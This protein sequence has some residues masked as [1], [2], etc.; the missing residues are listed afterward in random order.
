MK[1]KIVECR[2]LTI[3]ERVKSLFVREY[4]TVWELE[5]GKK[6]SIESS[7]RGGSWTELNLTPKIKSYLA[8][9]RMKNSIGYETELDKS[10]KISV[11]ESKTQ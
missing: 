8:D 3:R 2:K 5:D 11:L 4:L 9:L 7:I 6:I 10:L 1:A